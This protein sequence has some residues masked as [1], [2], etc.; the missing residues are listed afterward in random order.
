MGSD[1]IW[2]LIWIEDFEC[3]FEKT[4]DGLI[5]FIA[6]VLCMV[7]YLDAKHK[8]FS[9]DEEEDGCYICEDLSD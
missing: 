2:G 9:E 7:V 8:S 5:Y 3:V 4:K 1:W 6:G